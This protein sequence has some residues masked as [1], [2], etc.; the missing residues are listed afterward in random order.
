MKCGQD[1]PLVKVMSL[2]IWIFRVL[3]PGSPILNDRSVSPHIEIRKNA[4]KANARRE[5][6]ICQ[7]HRS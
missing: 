6:M 4:S 7:M 2:G 5:D 3:I 1:P